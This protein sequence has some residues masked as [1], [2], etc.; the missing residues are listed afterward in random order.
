MFRFQYSITTKASARGAWEVFADWTKW[1]LFA[2]IYGDVK[3][4]E[5]KPWKLGSRMEI[6]V[7]RPVEVVIDHQIICCEPAREVGW[8]DRA[9]GITIAQWVEF[10]EL[11]AERTRI[12]TWGELSPSE[13]KVGGRSVEQLVSSFVETWYENYRLACD[14]AVLS[15][16]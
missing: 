1:N 12:N 10:E 11:G 8:I 7:L 14:Q 3:W 15:N 5:G 9:L 6:E 16:N 4:L 13:A 2:N